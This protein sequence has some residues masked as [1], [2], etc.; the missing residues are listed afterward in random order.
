MFESLPQ[1]L[2]K[3]RVGGQCECLRAVTRGW[4]AHVVAKIQHLWASLAAGA[5]HAP[6]LLLSQLYSLEFS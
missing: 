1:T 5:L 2:W 4:Q 3:K 6:Y